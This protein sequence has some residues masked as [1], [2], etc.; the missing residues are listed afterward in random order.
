MEQKLPKHK[1]VSVPFSPMEENWNYYF[2]RTAD[3]KNYVLKVKTELIKVMQALD[4]DSEAPLKTREGDP[5][6]RLT[7]SQPIIVV[8]TVEEYNQEKKLRGLR[9]P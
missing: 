2:V 7:F 9:E 5:I 6:V 4:P 3:G 1:L 8:L